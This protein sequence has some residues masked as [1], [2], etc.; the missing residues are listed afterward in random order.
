VA[1]DRR[2]AIQEREW[3]LA[4]LRHAYQQLVD[5]VIGSWPGFAKGRLAPAIVYLE[6][7]QQIEAERDALLAEVERLKAATSGMADGDEGTVQDIIAMAV[8]LGCDAEDPNRAEI[9]RLFR[10]IMR[11]GERARQAERQRD[12][13]LQALQEMTERV[14]HWRGWAQFVYGAGGPVDPSKSDAELQ[15]RVAEVHDAQLGA[16]LAKGGA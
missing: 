13:A 1:E 9:I 15:M 6:R 11:Q 12:E 10:H 4:Q 8:R 14:D 16:A 7:E 2:T 3:A 5:L